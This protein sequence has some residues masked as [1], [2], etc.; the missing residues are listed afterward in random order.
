MVS[1]SGSPAYRRRIVDD[2]L[3][4]LL[5]SLPAIAL[6]GPKATGKTATG[7]QR[8][9]TVVPLDRPDTAEV[10]RADPDRILT[11]STP[12]LIDEWQRF[13]PSWDL[14][15]RAVD[16]DPRPGQFLLT[17]SASPSSP[18][19]HSGA[20]RIVNLRMRPLA[21]PERDG[22][23]PTVSLARLL[24]GVHEAI[25][26]AT[27]WNLETYTDHIIGGG[28]PGMQSV[29]AAARRALLDGYV[30]RIVDRDFPEAGRAVRNPAA[31]RR[32][33]A[34]FAAATGTV[35]SFET[36]RDAA[37]A[38][39]SDPPA[40]STTIPYRDT[41]ERIWVSDPV[42]AWSPTGHRLTRLTGNP[43][44]FL[45]DPALA[46]SLLDVDKE[47]LLDGRAGGPPIPRDG[48]LLGALFESLVALTVKV[49]AQAADARVGH[50][51][52]KGGEREI[53]FIVSGR[54][55]R[56]VAIEVKLSATVDNADVRHLLWLKGEMPSLT[57][58]VI[59]TTGREAYRRRD[60]VAVVPLAL[61]GP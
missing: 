1:V 6:D 9:R 51:R 25:E 15:R 50:L 58:L 3:D 48:T 29:P 55:G 12:I 31:L 61:L 56:A 59:L 42:P 40:K 39:Y 38:G 30:E 21:L 7:A 18:Q 17:G 46:V 49:L 22:S 36:I 57:D 14:V 24:A 33:L 52:T 19:T 4:V 54:G 13:E 11:G 2:Q 8:A 28:F 60:G 47:S 23:E 27:T 41:L 37:S 35:A 43:K 20:G 34:A 53:D 26:G 44:H 10:V 5:T 16:A 32:W 45:A